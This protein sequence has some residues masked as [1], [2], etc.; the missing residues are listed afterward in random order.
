MYIYLI[1]YSSA[2]SLIDNVEKFGVETARQ[3]YEHF[4]SVEANNKIEYS[5][6]N[7][8]I[9]QEVLS[10][11]MDTDSAYDYLLEE[12]EFMLR[13]EENIDWNTVRGNLGR[14]DVFSLMDKFK[15]EIS[16]KDYWMLI[17]YCYTTSDFC[18]NDYDI[19][20]Q[21][22]NVDR[23]K[24]EFIMNKEDREFYFNLPD[25]LKVYRGCSLTEIENGELRY[26]WTLNKDIATFFAHEYRRN[27]SVECDVI[28][29]TVT[30]KDILGYFNDRDEQEI[31]L[32]P[33]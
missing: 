25:L 32:I 11:E 22:L 15:N 6:D 28:E 31:L 20:K 19:L 30:K 8:R 23:P 2:K 13:K 5:E 24:R 27:E 7:E 29:R 18:Y 4:K 1:E 33:R 9:I 16:D 21:Y 17:G 10:G 14:N 12:A 26:S 3:F